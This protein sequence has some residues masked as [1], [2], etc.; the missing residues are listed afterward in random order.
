LGIALIPETE[1]TVI[2]KMVIFSFISE[3]GYRENPKAR[4]VGYA[5]QLMIL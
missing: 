2:S 4:Y 3:N 1:K 5:S